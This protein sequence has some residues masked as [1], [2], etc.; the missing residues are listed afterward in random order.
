MDERVGPQRRLSTKELMLLNCG[1]GEDSWELLGLQETKPV[2]PKGNQSWIFI[3]R[4]DA[5]AEIPILRPPD[6]KSQL[7]GK[8]LMLVK[9]EGKRRRGQQRMKWLDGI[10]D[11]MDLSLSKL[12]EFWRTEKPGMLLFKGLQRAEHTDQLNNN[13]KNFSKKV[14]YK[15]LHRNYYLSVTGLST[16]YRLAQSIITVNKIG[17]IT[18]LHEALRHRGVKNYVLKHKGF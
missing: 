2:N 7:T 10:T 1:V 17:W 4:T 5:E 12:Q 15:G 18:T 14:L 9:I 16:L 13:S 3:G 11:S 6:M 8:T